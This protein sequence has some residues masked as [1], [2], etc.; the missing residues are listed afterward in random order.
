MVNFYVKSSPFFGGKAIK[1]VI[2]T[3]GFKV[4]MLNSEDK[5][6]NQ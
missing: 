3:M 6:I 5:I 1:E 2:I 4:V